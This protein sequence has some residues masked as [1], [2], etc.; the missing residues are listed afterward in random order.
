[1]RDP[2][3]SGARDVISPTVARVAKAA[4]AMR[5]RFLA[6]RVRCPTMETTPQATAKP[7]RAAP[8][9]AT[10][11]VATRA[12]PPAAV[13][14]VTL[15]KTVVT[16]S[17]VVIARLYFLYSFWRAS[18]SWRN[19]ASILE[20]RCRCKSVVSTV[21]TTGSAAGHIIVIT[22]IDA[23]PMAVLSVVF[24]LQ[25]RGYPRFNLGCTCSGPF[26]LNGVNRSG[27][28]GSHQGSSYVSHYMTQ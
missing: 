21:G 23:V 16:V 22:T 18:C 8:G 4:W 14:T 19:S 28:Y 12:I 9:G 17:M 13:A 20:M 11:P 7:S 1:M 27:K 24:R 5:S 15:L 26:F 2:T 10:T 25:V 3:V 6:F